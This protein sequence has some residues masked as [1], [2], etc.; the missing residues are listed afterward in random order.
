MEQKITDTENQ[1]R[2]TSLALL[3]YVG[4]IYFTL[5]ILTPVCAHFV[6]IRKKRSHQATILLFKGFKIKHY[7]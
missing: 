5:H 2:K 7:H 1:G 3:E 6:V 4:N